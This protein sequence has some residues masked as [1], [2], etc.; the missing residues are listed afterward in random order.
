MSRHDQELESAL[1]RLVVGL[2]AADRLNL[3]ALTAE[4]VKRW[5]VQRARFIG[6]PYEKV[7]GCIQEQAGR[8]RRSGQATPRRPPPD[9]PTAPRQV[10][11]SGPRQAWGES[12]FARRRAAG[13]QVTGF[14][15]CPDPAVE[16][17]SGA[18]RSDTRRP[19]RRCHPATADSARR[20][21]NRWPGWSRA[22]P[23]RTGSGP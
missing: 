8:G 13:R 17:T 22:D 7:T 12:P 2:H 10:K 1:T 20:C 15:G 11:P 4:E 3:C 14:P 23:H 18:A 5:G 16:G 21:A 19:L 9:T 6:D